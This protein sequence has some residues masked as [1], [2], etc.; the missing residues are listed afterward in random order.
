[1]QALALLIV[2][3]FIY[4]FCVLAFNTWKIRRYTDAE[5]RQ[6][7]REAELHPIFS[8]NVPFGAKALEQRVHVEGIWVSPP[9]TPL[10]SALPSA[11]PSISPPSPS[12]ER[13]SPRSPTPES[14]CN[15][16]GANAIFAKPSVCGPAE[17]ASDRGSI[18]ENQF[19]VE[20]HESKTGKVP[21]ASPETGG[22]KVAFTRAYHNKSEDQRSPL[23][24]AGNTP[25]WHAGSLSEA[26]LAATSPLCSPSS[27]Q[28][29]DEA[30]AWR[31]EDAFNSRLR[32]VLR[33]QSQEDGR[34]GVSAIL[35]EQYRMAAPSEQPAAES[36][37]R[38]PR[39][40]KRRKSILTQYRSMNG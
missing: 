37:V 8:D 14:S 40:R 24:R 38:P 35:N 33:K 31:N 34:R 7:D 17:C 19:A 9:S 22:V 13:P 2:L 12:P 36:N 23:K 20:I 21:V 10:T 30:N 5:L 3:V 25:M 4:A 32:S 39:S 1:M 18:T 26:N 11:S 16:E 15:R 6:R 27:V 28:S 29:I